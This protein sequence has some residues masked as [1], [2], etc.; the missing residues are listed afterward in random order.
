MFRFTAASLIVFDVA[1][2]THRTVL[3]SAPEAQPQDWVITTPF[4]P[5]KLAYGL[6]TFVVGLDGIELSP[7]GAWLYFGAMSHDHLYKVPTAALRD[8]SDLRGAISAVGKK[9][10]SDG[11][12]LDR[13]G[14]VVLT[15]IE[16]AGLARLD[17]H[18]LQ[19]LVRVPGV[20]WADGV[21]IAPDGAVVFTD[22]AIPAYIDQLARPPTQARLVAGR[23]YH[24]YRVAPR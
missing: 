10:L 5:H 14:A 6:I 9:P 2:R 7:D 4:G 18:G 15:D 21:V 22:S 13:D 16:H 20:V 12:T 17:E 1:T 3:A 23:P 8:G 24:I 11:I 19:T